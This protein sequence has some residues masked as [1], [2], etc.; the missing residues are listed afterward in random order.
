LFKNGSLVEFSHGKNLDCMYIKSYVAIQKYSNEME[1]FY[2]HYK[3]SK[4]LDF[5]VNNYYRL[6][7]RTQHSYLSSIAFVSIKFTGV[8]INYFNFKM[9]N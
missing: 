5:C 6:I 1:Q 2:T 3:N 8:K 4:L 7:K 9:N